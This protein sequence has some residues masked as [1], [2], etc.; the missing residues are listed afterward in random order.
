MEGERGWHIKVG[1]GIE[2]DGG[3]NPLFIFLSEWYNSDSVT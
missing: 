3:Q 2:D 1:N